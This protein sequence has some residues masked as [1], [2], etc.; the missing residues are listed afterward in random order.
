V[1]VT[2]RPDERSD[3]VLIGTPFSSRPTTD[4]LRRVRKRIFGAMCARGLEDLPD[5]GRDLVVQPEPVPVCRK[6]RKSVLARLPQPAPISDAPPA[7]AR[8]RGPSRSGMIPG[9]VSLCRTGST[10]PLRTLSL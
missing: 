9:G 10:A 8:A 1:R 5:A 7:H 3:T 2:A 4:A 6:T